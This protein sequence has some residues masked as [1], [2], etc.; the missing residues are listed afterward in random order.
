MHRQFT[1]RL[2]QA[3]DRQQL[4]DFFPG[5]TATITAQFLLPEAIQTQLLP[6]QAS[7]PAIAETA[8][9]QQPHRAE[10]QRQGV[11]LMGGN[12]LVAGEQ[13][14]LARLAFLFVKNFDGL[15]PG[16]FLA[17]VDLAEIKH[18]PL[19]RLAVGQAA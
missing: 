3:V 6:Q 18:L 10:L 4:Q 11:D 1:A 8:R 2:A 15:A 17:V 14:H 13:R 19:R 16:G 12:R 7:Q 9:T 5:H